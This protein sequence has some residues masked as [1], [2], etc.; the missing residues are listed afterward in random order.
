MLESGISM[1]DNESPF[2]TEPI[3]REISYDCLFLCELQVVASEFK[4]GRTQVLDVLKLD[5]LRG[6]RKNLDLGGSFRSILLI[7][8]IFSFFQPFW[9]LQLI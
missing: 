7:I 1:L 4:L 9:P 6:L 3:L 5:L 2:S 8:I